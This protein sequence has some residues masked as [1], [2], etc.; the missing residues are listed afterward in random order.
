MKNSY[1]KFAKMKEFSEQLK[2]YFDKSNTSGNENEFSRNN[3][4]SNIS[5]TELFARHEFLCK[6]GEIP[7]IDFLQEKK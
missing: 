3:N 7:D 6:C 4:S 2:E 5:K 1:L